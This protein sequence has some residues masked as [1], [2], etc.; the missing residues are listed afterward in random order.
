MQ[1][2]RT[3]YVRTTNGDFLI[4]IPADARITFG[5]VVPRRDERGY[6]HRQ[7]YG[8]RI[9]VDKDHQI[10]AFAGVTEYWDTSM[11]I[12]R[13]KT[14]TKHNV[15]GN[16]GP[17]GQKVEK[18]DVTVSAWVTEDYPT[19]LPML[20]SGQEPDDTEEEIPF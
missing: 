20:E 2:T 14:V 4:D 19:A 10:A 15:E 9:W 13:R 5:A 8:L 3:L 18:A 6:D 17:N 11:R 7:T 1:E 12:Q 16:Y